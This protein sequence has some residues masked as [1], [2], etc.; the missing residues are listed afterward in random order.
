MQSN[1]RYALS[2]FQKKVRFNKK[3]YLINALCLPEVFLASQN[4]YETAAHFYNC[5]VPVGEIVTHIVS[6]PVSQMCPEVVE[7]RM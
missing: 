3:I 4:V 1:Y 2:F 7:G 6:Q 5:I